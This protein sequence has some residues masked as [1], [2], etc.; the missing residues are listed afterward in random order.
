MLQEFSSMTLKV[1]ASESGQSFNGTYSYDVVRSTSSAYVVKVVVNASSGSESYSETYEFKVTTSGTLA[2]SYYGGENSTSSSSDV[3]IG[4]M[5]FFIIE[6]PSNYVYTFSQFSQYFH[7]SGSGTATIPS[8]TVDYTTYTPN[9][10]PVSFSECGESFTYQT[11]NLEVGP[12]QGTSTSVMVLLT[13]D[14]TVAGQSVN[15]TIQLIDA[16]L[17]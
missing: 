17:E 15:F 9:S 14:G 13:A 10:T 8:I 2:W 5:A 4:A 16:T 1:S 12:V 6:S 11:F 7:A 3:F